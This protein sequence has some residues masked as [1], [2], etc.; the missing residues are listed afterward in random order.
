MNVF[1]WIHDFYKDINNFDDKKT[2]ILNEYKKQYGE[3]YIKN[4][5]SRYWIH[6]GGRANEL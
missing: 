1:P 3:N 2:H 5:P 4:I 6:F